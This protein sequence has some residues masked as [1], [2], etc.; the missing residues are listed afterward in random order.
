[1]P[2]VS[3]ELQNWAQEKFGDIDNCG[4]HKF[5]KEQGYILTNNYFWK[6]PKGKTDPSE[7]EANAIAFLM[8]RW[9]YGGIVRG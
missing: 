4:P 1:M 3:D 8:E 7:E 2:L 9:Y 5:L 6:L